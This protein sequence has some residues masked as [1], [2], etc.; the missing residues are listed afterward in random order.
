[1]GK[2]PSN[3][4]C[5]IKIENKETSTIPSKIPFIQDHDYLEGN[6][7]EDTY[8]NIDDF[9]TDE[10]DGCFPVSI[11]HFDNI[12]EEVLDKVYKSTNS[13]EIKTDSEILKAAEE[14][15]QE[16]MGF[17]MKHV[18]L[19]S[20]VNMIDVQ[21]EI[22]VNNKATDSTCKKDDNDFEIGQ[23]KLTKPDV[24]I[25][26][27]MINSNTIEDKPNMDVV[28][29][30]N[31]FSA[32]NF[33]ITSVLDITNGNNFPYVQNF[34][35]GFVDLTQIEKHDHLN[36]EAD[37][38]L[39]SSSVGVDLNIP[40]LFDTDDNL[41]NDKLL[42]VA[43]EKYIFLNSSMDFIEPDFIIPQIKYPKISISDWSSDHG[44]ENI[45]VPQDNAE[46]IE[47]YIPM[48][49]GKSCVS[50]NS[51]DTGY[52]SNQDDRLS[53]TP[54]PELRS[55]TSESLILYTTNAKAQTNNEINST[56]NV[57]TEFI[58][59]GTRPS[60]VY[61]VNDT[62]FK[63]TVKGR[64]ERRQLEQISRTKPV[65]AIKSEPPQE[66]ST[67]VKRGRKP[68]HFYEDKITKNKML[69]SAY[70]AKR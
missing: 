65:I 48:D 34:S 68:I 46:N 63:K 30:S 56:S 2:N 6:F 43:E 18:E 44:S 49:E 15:K 31:Y 39:D 12:Q 41:N 67:T 33:E 5:K 59:I 8:K 9:G 27:E 14:V 52:C 53:L 54:S 29:D 62:A 21:D 28:N 70:R 40:N 26:N 23:V 24:N 10:I 4:V 20:K 45:Q 57:E 19:E 55:P 16:N 51:L 38:V 37:K 58:H 50:S 3:N 60:K 61:Y 69:C 36:N 22:T 32:E 1:M 25:P 17:S 42:N 13:S 11:K 35:K 64:N 66:K 47:D 7:K